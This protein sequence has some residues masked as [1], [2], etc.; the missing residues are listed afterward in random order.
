MVVLTVE[1]TRDFG[2]SNWLC[3]EWVELGEGI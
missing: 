2:R 3:L 1:G